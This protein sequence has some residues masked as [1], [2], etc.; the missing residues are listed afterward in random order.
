MEKGLI[1]AT[2]IIKQEI[3]YAK[4]VNPIMA[5]G[6]SQVLFLINKEISLEKIKKNINMEDMKND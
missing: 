2:E 1:R 5:L 3:E 6:M 4:T